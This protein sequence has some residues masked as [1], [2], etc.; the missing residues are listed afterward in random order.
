MS[1]VVYLMNIDFKRLQLHQVT[2]FATENGTFYG[3]GTSD[4]YEIGFRDIFLKHFLIS[5]SLRFIPTIVKSTVATVH[6]V[7]I[8]PDTLFGR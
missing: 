4:L 8:Y 3:I 6:P 1:V 5:E 7:S 2:C